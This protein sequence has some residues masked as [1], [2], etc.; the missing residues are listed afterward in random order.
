[1]KDN[2]YHK[3]FDISDLDP[4]T[5]DWESVIQM[6]QDK[7]ETEAKDVLGMI[8]RIDMEPVPIIKD[9]GSHATSGIKFTAFKQDE[10]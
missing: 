7:F 8:A 6:L 9:D 1:M 3:V 4:E 10:K 5:T 2:I